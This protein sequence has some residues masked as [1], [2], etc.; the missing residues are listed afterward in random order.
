MKFITIIPAYNEEAAINKVVSSSLKYSDVLV[1]DDGSSDQT[2]GL[3]RQAGARVIKHTKNK[4]KGAA[5][6]SGIE[7]ALKEEYQAMIMLD[8]DGQHDPQFIPG[9]MNKLNDADFIICS[10]FLE[11]PPRKMALGR[12]ISN[13]LTTSLLRYTTGY[14]VTDSQCGFRA[15]SDKAARIFLSIPYDD[16]EFESEMLY[17][18][19]LNKLTIK[20]MAIPSSYQGEKSYITSIKIMKYIYYILKLLLRDLKRRLS[21]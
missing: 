11:G 16:Y 7:Y 4:G 5:I 19:S 20:E 14:H 1:V 18:A 8:G 10:R 13:K 21:H 17:L 15:F 9:S 2:G 3:S 6:K 12:K